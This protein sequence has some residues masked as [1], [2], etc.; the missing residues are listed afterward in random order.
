M[1]LSSLKNLKTLELTGL[2]LRD[3]D[4]ASLAGMSRLEWLV[5][6]GATFTE[7][8]LRHLQDL[9]SVKILTIRDLDCPTGAGLA[10]S[11]RLAKL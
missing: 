3:A 5:L 7:A 4:L 1:A 8:G 6:Q 11:I 10:L 2:D 9:A